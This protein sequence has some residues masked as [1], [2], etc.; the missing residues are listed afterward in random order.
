MTWLFLGLLLICSACVSCSETALFGLT[1]RTLGH[2][3][4][5]T[6]P[7]QRRVATLMANPR[8]VLLTVLI[9]NT[10]VNVAIFAVSFVALEHFRDLY[11]AQAA[12]AGVAVLLVVIVFGEVLPKAV[13]L[14]SPVRLSPMAAALLTV[15][16][17]VL[18]PLRL[19]LDTVLVEPVTRL[20]SPARPIADRLTTDELRLLLER[21]AR[22]GHI[23][24]TESEMLQAVVALG[25]V[26][27]REVMTPRV[28]LDAVSLAGDRAGVLANFDRTK[29]RRLPAYGRDLDDIRGLL[30]VRDLLLRPEAGL[31]A[32][33]RGIHFVPEQ[34]N[35]IQLLRS[36]REARA[37]LAIVVDEYGGTAGL[38][39]IE[40][41]VEWIVGELPDAEAPREEARPEKLDETTYRLPGDLSVRVWAD[42]FAVGEIDRG[43]DT[44]GGL[45]LSK[46]GRLPRP[47]DR[48]GLRN[49]T[50]T[51]ESVRRRRVERVLLHLETDGTGTTG[52]ER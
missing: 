6:N 37:H 15:L 49:L 47:G 1:R 11:P 33:L 38:V 4:R 13:A 23:N 31:R 42:R 19:L 8:R 32:L 10:A 21:S 41:V 22:E 18:A 14:R 35:L 36:L 52:G 48:V 17:T 25:E 28:D 29:R 12:A 7:L 45:V 43:I 24:T 5:G 50:L 51:V 16:Q 39:T 20:L 2:F 9:A 34:V 44:V 40:D 46:L 27:V 26:G 3:R 30:Y